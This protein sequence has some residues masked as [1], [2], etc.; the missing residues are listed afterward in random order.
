[1][2][3]GEGRNWLWY[4]NRSVGHPT[5]EAVIDDLRRLHQGVHR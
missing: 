4:L 2:L 3:V 5:I 1:V